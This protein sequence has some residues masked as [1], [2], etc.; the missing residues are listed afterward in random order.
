MKLGLYA[1][2]DNAV[3]AFMP[4]LAFRSK[5]EA[6]RSFADACCQEGSQFY[7]HAKDYGFFHLGSYDDSLG[8]VD[9]LPVPELVLSGPAA[10]S[11][12]EG[13]VD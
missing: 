11:Y 3:S 12:I 4:P 7:K 2:Y 1:V 5:G 13:T 6:L 10:K 8:H 9:N